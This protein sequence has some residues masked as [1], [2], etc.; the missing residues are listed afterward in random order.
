MSVSDWPKWAD[1][2]WL[3]LHEGPGDLV[4]IPVAPTMRRITYAGERYFRAP[5]SRSANEAGEYGGFYL[6]EGWLPASLAEREVAES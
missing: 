2:T 1:M 5:N 4:V 6:W 3:R